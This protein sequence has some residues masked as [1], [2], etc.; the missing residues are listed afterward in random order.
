M[1]D[2]PNPTLGTLLRDL[3]EKLD[4]AVERSYVDSGLDYRPRYTPVMRALLE[5][6]PASIRSISRAAGIT[7][8]A[9]SQTVA[10]MVEKGLVQL[11]P[12]GDAR[13]RIVVLTPAAK[14][15]IP[16]LKRHWSATNEAARM[17]DSELSVPLSDV[18]KEAIDALDRAS[19]TQR[20][21][22]AAKG[23]RSKRRKKT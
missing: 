22:A 19:F 23:A 18:L 13:E 17:L 4:G 5:S 3:I 6:G 20:I 8:S 12:G 11:E 7:H 2:R 16:K 14:A 15:M 1:L 21:D 10:Q 9:A